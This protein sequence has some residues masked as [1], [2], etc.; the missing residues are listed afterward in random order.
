MKKA[1]DAYES[2]VNGW[3]DFVAHIKVHRP[4]DLNLA[5]FGYGDIDL[6]D[7]SIPWESWKIAV[8]QPDDQNDIS[9]ERKLVNCLNSIR[10]PLSDA[11]NNGVKWLFESTNFLVDV[12]EVSQIIFVLIPAMKGLSEEIS[13]ANIQAEK[14][15][16]AELRMQNEKIK[17]EIKTAKENTEAIAK[18]AG[19]VSE[20]KTTLATADANLI[21]ANKK[22]EKA[23]AD[24]NKQGLSEAFSAAAANFDNQRRLFGVLF[25]FALGG[26]FCIGLQ[27]KS[28]FDS[29]GVDYKFLSGFTLAA[30]LVWLGWFSARQ[31]GQLARV[32][33]D[34][35]YKKATAL[36]FEA[37]KKEVVDAADT[38]LSK[39]LLETVIKNFGDNPVRLLPNSVSDHGHPMEELLS[40]LSDGKVVDQLIKSLEVWKK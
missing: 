27:S 25:L 26:L 31:I 36:A 23:T 9:Y 3:G 8:S 40:K 17:D 30:P 15:A 24:L 32:Q 10:S 29:I 22:V 1:F 20:I 12:A 5:Q 34:Y 21:E 7:I 2:L 11:K 39:K 4:Q 33:Q 28:A 19:E 37:H 38:E 16:A 13:N 35:E 18:F 14:V 6:A